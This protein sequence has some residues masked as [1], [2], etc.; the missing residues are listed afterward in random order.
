[1]MY[2]KQTLKWI[3]YECAMMLLAFDTLVFLSDA[4]ANFENITA[5]DIL[6]RTLKTVTSRPP[7]MAD[8]DLHGK[9]TD[10]VEGIREVKY[11]SRV[12]I[13]N[14]QH[15][16]TRDTLY[17]IDG[18]WAKTSEHRGIWDGSRYTLRERS[19][20]S[21]TASG[22]LWPG[23][24]YVV[25]KDKP[26]TVEWGMRTYSLAGTTRD[27]HFAK[28]L[29][30]SETLRLRPE[31]E[32][33]DGFACYVVE[34]DTPSYYHTV[35]IDP[36]NGYLHRKIICEGYQKN[37][38]YEGSWIIKSGIE[39]TDVKIEYF[40]GIP[41]VTEAKRHSFNER[42]DGNT[43]DA[44]SHEKMSNVVW[45][46]DFESLGAFKMD[47]VPD[48]TRVIYDVNDLYKTGVKFHWQGGRIVPNVDEEVIEQI[49]RITEELMAEGQVPAGLATAKKTEAAP[50]QPAGIAET[51]VT[52]EKAQGEI[53]SES[54]PFPVVVLIPIGLL[55]IGLIGWLVF[56]RLKA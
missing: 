40:E 21:Y 17:L 36:Q 5:K 37:L 19:M 20:P 46:P 48:G 44:I 11:V 27:E 1:M 8:G 6:Q 16:T 34:G 4:K 51:Q 3:V 50:N 32:Q 29:L 9:W 52:T 31:M 10:S 54:R 24:F 12:Y 53:L 39:V 43:L 56:R 38:P 15:D 28:L 47:K 49:D 2:A 33:V 45:N 23:D 55:I 35:W 18:K 41:V 26:H 22:Y 14:Q 42:T 30:E 13:R 7:M 25:Y